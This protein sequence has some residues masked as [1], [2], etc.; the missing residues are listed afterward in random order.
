MKDIARQKEEISQAK[1]DFK[2]KHHN[3]FLESSDYDIFLKALSNKE[4][5]LTQ[6][7]IEMQKLQAALQQAKIEI[8]A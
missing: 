2:T 3:S 8:K 6:D 4:S 7:I 5:T 1:A